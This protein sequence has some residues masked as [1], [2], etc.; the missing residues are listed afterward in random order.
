MLLR[1]IKTCKH[2]SITLP[3]RYYSSELAIPN[4]SEYSTSLS[5]A[6]GIIGSAFWFSKNYK[7]SEPGQYIVKTGLGIKLMHISKTTFRLPFQKTEFID[8]TPKTYSFEL[9]AMSNQKMEFILPVVFTIGPKDDLQELIKFS[10]YML[11]TNNSNDDNNLRH[12]VKGIIEGETRVLCASMTIEDIFS[13]RIKFKTDIINN[14]QEELSKFGLQIHNA[15]IKELQDKEGS[16]FFTFMRQKTRAEAEGKARIDTAEAKKNADIQQK[17]KITESRKKIAEFEA[18]AV[19][20]ENLSSQEIL[21][22]NADLEVIRANTK[23]VQDIAKIEAESLSK[24]KQE[25]MNTNVEA[26]KQLAQIEAI[27]AKNLSV[28]KVNAEALKIDTE[29]KGIAL[30]IEAEAK[31]QALKVDAEANAVSTMTLADANLYQQEKIAEGI[32][33]TYNAQANGISNLGESFGGDHNKFL[34]YYMIEKE[35]YKSL[36]DASANAIKD[37]KPQIWS[38]NWTNDNIN[39]PIKN[40]MKSIPPILKT[41]HDQTGIKLISDGVNE[42]ENKKE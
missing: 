21:K 9:E 33:A 13:D 40:I 34:Q 30:K 11:S 14:I 32:K 5:L 29:A 1:N 28:A 27:R 36:A 25:E 23:K 39:D 6:F 41:I 31:A 2:K 7:V 18:S 19:L 17:E 8:L 20:A 35:T 4:F 38:M 12:M 3:K 26:A 15:N 42:N 16:E 22:S 24:I 10:T 37:M